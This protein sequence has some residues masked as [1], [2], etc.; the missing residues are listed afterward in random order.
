MF[1]FSRLYFAK[2][3]PSSRRLQYFSSTVD[4]VRRVFGSP[5]HH[6][7][8]ILA[9]FLTS[10]V[11]RLR[12]PH[13]NCEYLSRR[14]PARRRR[15]DRAPKSRRIAS[16][17]EP[18]RHRPI[19]Y[20]LLILAWLSAATCASTPQPITIATTTSVVNSGL[21]DAILPQFH[22][23]TVRIH[24]AGSGRALAMLVDHS[25]DLVISHA[26]EAE[27]QT[28]A[29]HPDW[30]YQKL[31]YNR[32][33]LIGPAA[34]PAS[35]R[36]A[37]NLMDA[38]RRIAASGVP[39]ISRGDGSGTHERETA[40]WKL[41]GVKPSPDHFLVSGGSMAITL[42]QAAS[43]GAYTLSDEATWRQLEPRLNALA[44]LFTGAAPELLNTYAVIHRGDNAPAAT[45]AAWLLTGDGREHISAY[46]IGG[47]P[48][49]TVWPTACPG[50][51]P[52]AA[53]CGN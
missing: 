15:S 37:S 21:L 20:G 32:F 42:R 31:A 26:P 9:V 18:R 23:G 13:K 36:A 16:L 28:L 39:F 25:V 35:V 45:F 50:N 44:V 27:Q 7:H 19:K 51:L 12:L 41:A 29:Q 48:A 40:L 2:F 24:A 47:Q 33:V 3:L 43:V 8:R 4:L 14:L 30:H 1:S 17:V 46:Q 6:P 38:L 53:L 11:V 22:N 34:D 52:N 5:I 49:F 10:T